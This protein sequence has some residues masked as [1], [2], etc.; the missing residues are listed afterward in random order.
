MAGGKINVHNVGRLGVNVDASEVYK[1]DGELTQAQNAVPIDDGLGK[2]PGLVKVNAIAA[3]GSILGG[4][5]VPL[6][7]LT[8]EVGG[9][10]L[11][12]APSRKIF[13][14]RQEKDAGVSGM[15]E[16][17][18]GWW[19]STDKFAT[20]AT[21]ISS[22]TPA[23][24]RGDQV[25]FAAASKQ[26]GWHIGSPGAA[27]VVKNR[28]IYAADGYSVGGAAP[29]RAFDGSVDQEIARITPGALTADTADGYGVMS[30]LAVNDNTVYLTVYRR[31]GGSAHGGFILSLN[32]STGAIAE[33]GTI[34]LATDQ[35]P[36]CLAWHMGRLWMGTR[37]NDG[38]GFT[39][40]QIWWIRPGIDTAWTLDRTMAVGWGCSS[41]TSFQG[42]LFAGSICSSADDTVVE[43]RS[44]VGAWTTSLTITTA[45]AS[46]FLG[47]VVFESN[48]YIAHHMLTSLATVIK[49][50]DGSSWSTVFTGSGGAGVTERA[51]PS[52]F[53]DDTT[54]YFGGGG[55]NIG[56][57]LL[58]S[59][60]GSSWTNRTANLADVPA[61][62]AFGVLSI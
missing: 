45:E 58:T 29:I 26:A 47:A 33:L 4:V 17:S 13:W 49:K 25:E 34:A 46:S 1:E 59:T 31:S 36:Y 48:L 21:E 42:Q 23:N 28:L 10:S 14:G 39:A 9:T 30:M 37:D 16:A 35:I 19:T 15:G 18:L 52:A 27:C 22:G 54:V 24:P 62:T 53:I 5:G 7:L 56:A 57:I 38:T 61:L 8:N 44:S 11:G 2:R 60:D 41:L 20:A 55:A 40:G 6:V 12:A 51:M 43:V 50:F 3:A 32:P